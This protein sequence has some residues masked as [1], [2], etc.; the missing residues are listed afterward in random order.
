MM[1]RHELQTRI[2]ELEHRVL[3]LMRKVA[4]LKARP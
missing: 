1:T 2:R 4:A 3:N